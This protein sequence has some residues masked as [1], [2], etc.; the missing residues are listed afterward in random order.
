[1]PRTVNPFILNFKIM[2]WSGLSGFSVS[3]S[4]VVCAKI[5]HSRKVI[6]LVVLEFIVPG[7]VVR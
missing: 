7:L 3:R 2:V 4:R 6:G 5:D 1:M